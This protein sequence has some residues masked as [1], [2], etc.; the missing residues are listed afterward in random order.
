MSLRLQSQ[1]NTLFLH[2]LL[3]SNGN[4][5]WGSHSIL[6][7]QLLTRKK[8]KSVNKIGKISS[9]ANSWSRLAQAQL[10]CRCVVCVRV[11]HLYSLNCDP[12]EGH[13]I[14]AKTLV[15]LWKNTEGWNWD[16]CHI[17]THTLLSNQSDCV[18]WLYDYSQ[19]SMLCV[20]VWWVCVT[21]HV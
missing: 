15:Y 9:K 18:K 2:H 4:Y 21:S 3:C 7:S 19:L 11:E 1:R 20:C 6:R 14:V 5:V 17:M 10:A 8:G 13:S 16:Y 12:D